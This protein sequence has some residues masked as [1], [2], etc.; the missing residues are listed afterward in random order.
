MFFIGF[1]M[2]LCSSKLQAE[3]GTGG[4]T[5][6]TT[7]WLERLAFPNPLSTRRLGAVQSMLVETELVLL[8]KSFLQLD[9]N[10]F[11]VH[12]VFVVGNIVLEA[13]EDNKQPARTLEYSRCHVL[14]N[15]LLWH[16]QLLNGSAYCCNRAERSLSRKIRGNVFLM[17]LFICSGVNIKPVLFCVTLFFFFL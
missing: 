13:R 6:L 3:Q 9:A 4:T 15:N 16:I 17:G 7:C 1:D 10:S 11:Y 14:C 12:V 2:I 5:E 8:E